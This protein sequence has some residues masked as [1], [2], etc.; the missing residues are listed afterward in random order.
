MDAKLAKTLDAYKRRVEGL[1]RQG[2][3]L[4]RECR[5]Q[6]AAMKAAKLMAQGATA[7]QDMPV[8]Q[9]LWHNEMGPNIPFSINSLRRKGQ[10][11]TGEITTVTRRKGGRTVEIVQNPNSGR[12]E[13]WGPEESSEDREHRLEC[14]PRFNPAERYETPSLLEPARRR[15]VEYIAREDRCVIA[16]A[17]AEAAEAAEAAGAE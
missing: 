1:K 16:L 9:V 4:L 11:Y 3:T 10:H 5:Q 8:D 13:L 6:A 17:D 7:W 12:W 2:K 14:Q 15:A